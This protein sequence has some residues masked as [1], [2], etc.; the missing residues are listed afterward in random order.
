[1]K[2]SKRPKSK[3]EWKFSSKEFLIK[4][5]CA[6]WELITKGSIKECALNWI[7][8][9]SY[10]ARFTAKNI[11]AIRELEIFLSEQ[12]KCFD[13]LYTDQNRKHELKLWSVD[14][15]SAKTKLS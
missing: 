1:M 3:I 8:I 7:V 4:D 15:F 6:H 5:F 11:C 10:C 9:K 12:R 13:I 14:V 2:L